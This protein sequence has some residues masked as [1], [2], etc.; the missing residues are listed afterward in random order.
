MFTPAGLPLGLNPQQPGHV[1][2]DVGRKKRFGQKRSRPS[3]YQSS[4]QGMFATARQEYRQMR[5]GGPQL[6][7]KVTAF[8]IRQ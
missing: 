1:P 5:P 2:L 6:L 3:L 4:D 8:S 7:A